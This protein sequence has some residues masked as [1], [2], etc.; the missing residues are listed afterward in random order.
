MRKKLREA[1]ARAKKQGYAIAIG[2]PKSST[3][4]ALANSADI[5][6]EVEL[7]YLDAIYEYYE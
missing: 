7:V 4:R 6:V 5:L 2:H 3:L 1:V